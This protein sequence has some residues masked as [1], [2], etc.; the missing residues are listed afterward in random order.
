MLPKMRGR[1]QT[2][3]EPVGCFFILLLTGDPFMFLVIF[4]VAKSTIYLLIVS[5][6]QTCTITKIH[7]MLHYKLVTPTFDKHTAYTYTD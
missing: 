6:F 7:R 3:F 5:A 2:C 1:S 4:S